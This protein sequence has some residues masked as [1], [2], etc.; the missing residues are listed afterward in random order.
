MF[1][2]PW[3]VH[4]RCSLGVW[5]TPLH[6]APDLGAVLGVSELWLKRDDLT[7]F[8]WGGNK[9]RTAEFLL[10]EALDGGVQELVVCGGPSSNFVAILAAAAAT[11]GIAVTQVSYGCEPDRATAALVAARAT[12]ATV[13]FTESA[14]RDTMETFGAEVV[15]QRNLRGVRA[16]L[17]PRGGA[18]VTG[19][20]GF[21]AAAAEIDAQL[22]EQLADAA[23]T[24]MIVIPVGSGGSVA[25]LI[26]GAALLGRRWR[27]V[28]VSVSRPP[29]RLR[30]L[31]DA[32]VA[33]LIAELS[34]TR[35]APDWELHD[36]LG[37]GFGTAD[38]AESDIARA[39]S[40][41]T[42][43]VVDPTYNAK[44]LTWLYRQ[45]DSAGPVIYWNTGGA[46]GALDA[47]SSP[48]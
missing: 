19:A 11:A 18:S 15:R 25:G 46:L 44:A 27:I 42:G 22:D 36:G 5:P 23:D 29:Q 7:G 2:Q 35:A 31:I 32:R 6:R 41:R 14:D 48:E 39:V 12:G 26:A 17:V 34:G 37:A 47:R 1:T 4:R 8:S 45:P 24:C 38:A 3:S 33:Q 21:V 20:L 40:S 16:S 30:P 9:V 43:L 13:V 28:G 10:G